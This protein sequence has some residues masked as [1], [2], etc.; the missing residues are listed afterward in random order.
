MVVLWKCEWR[1][2]Y[3]RDNVVPYMFDFQQLLAVCNGKT[4]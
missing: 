2:T 1:K 3:M 4:E